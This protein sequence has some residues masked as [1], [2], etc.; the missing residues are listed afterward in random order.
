MAGN[1]GN[2]PTTLETVCTTR[3]LARQYLTKIFST[4]AKADIITPIR[5][6]RGGYLLSRDPSEIS[7]LEIL[8]TVEGPITLNLCQATPPKCDNTSCPLRPVWAELQE[9]IRGRL[10]RITLADCL[11]GKQTPAMA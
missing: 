10:S 1:H 11:N 7:I 5:G 3:N 9:V 4:L 2:G 6:K 8:E